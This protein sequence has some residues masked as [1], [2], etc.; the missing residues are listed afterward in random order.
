MKV[1]LFLLIFVSSTSILNAG[2]TPNVEVVD[3]NLKNLFTF[4]VDKSLVGATV[5][6]V[7]NNGDIVTTEKLIKKKMIIDF[8]DVKSGEYQVVIKKGEYHKKYG[9]I[10]DATEGVVLKK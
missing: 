3:A 6:L 4:K 7:F 1:L 10:K 9:I 8:C 2:T 5:E